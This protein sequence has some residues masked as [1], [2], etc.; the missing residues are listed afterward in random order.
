MK[1]DSISFETTGEAEDGP[2]SGLVAKETSR[3]D[4]AAGFCGLTVVCQRMG[5][6]FP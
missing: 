3:P 5:T 1:H 4:E 2:G 6:I